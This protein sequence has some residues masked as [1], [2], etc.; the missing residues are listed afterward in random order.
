MYLILVAIP[1]GSFLIS[2][3]FLSRACEYVK[4]WKSLQ[5]KN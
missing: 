4:N 1:I 2:I 5:E 3:Q